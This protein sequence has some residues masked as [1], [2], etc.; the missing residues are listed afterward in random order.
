MG[1]QRR[2][3]DQVGVIEH[4]ALGRSR[5]PGGVLQECQRVAVNVRH[6]PLLV[7]PLRDLRGGQPGELL[8]VRSLVDQPLDTTEHKVRGQGHVGISVVRDCLD[9]RQR[10]VPPRGINRNRHDSRVQTAE[11]RS[12]KLQ[13]RR[14]QQQCPLPRQV[15]RLQPGPDGPGL[16]VQLLVAQV[17][18]V[19]LAVDQVRK[20]D[21]FRLA[22]GTMLQQLN[23]I[24]GTEKGTRQ[25]IQM[26][27]HFPNSCHKTADYPRTAVGF[28][29]SRQP[30]R[31]YPK[32]S[33]HRA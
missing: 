12:H 4:H 8:Q 14:I 18:L 15:Q 27:H 32:S 2:V 5:R 33:N 9:P 1:D 24:G 23:Q 31:L 21:V 19:V 25:V 3:V 26:M 28:R 22:T 11:E 20:R 29:V 13:A 17:N 10:A 7:H 6:L 16:A 30:I